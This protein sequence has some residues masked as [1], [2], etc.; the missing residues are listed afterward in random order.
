MQHCVV[1]HFTSCS[2]S[3]LICVP[4]VTQTHIA[5]LSNVEKKS[6]QRS[7]MKVRSVYTNHDNTT[8][9]TPDYGDDSF[10]RVSV[11]YKR[12]IATSGTGNRERNK[13]FGERGRP[14][15]H[16]SVRVREWEWEWEGVRRIS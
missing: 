1:I 4:Y 9:H 11:V 12:I 6:K 14:G 10:K 15:V 2:H 5:N 7:Y 13:T 3:H 16:T 8:D